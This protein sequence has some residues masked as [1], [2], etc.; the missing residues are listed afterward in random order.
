VQCPALFPSQVTTLKHLFL[1]NKKIIVKANKY[2]I[3]LILF[4]SIKDKKTQDLNHTMD[5]FPWTCTS[6]LV[7][8]FLL[9]NNIPQKT[10]DFYRAV[11]KEKKHVLYPFC[12]V[13]HS[14]LFMYLKKFPST[15]VE[16]KTFYF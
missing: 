9:H 1:Y 15:C 4:Y 8:G 11:S 2:T 14:D 10:D 5:N 12:S 7:S 3:F 13:S 6:K 16:T